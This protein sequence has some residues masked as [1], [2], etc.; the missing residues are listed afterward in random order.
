MKNGFRFKRNSGA[1]NFK[2]YKAKP[3]EVFP[4]NML[5]EIEGEVFFK[6][7]GG[8]NLIVKKHPSGRGEIYARVGESA[9]DK[10]K[11]EDAEKVLKVLEEL[12]AKNVRI[13]KFFITQDRHVIYLEKGK[14]YY[15]ALL[16]KG[17]EFPEK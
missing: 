8:R 9:E 15:I 7:K 10:E 17:L 11:G 3:G 13:N 5:T 4:D 14:Y 1:S 2:E 16:K 6:K 12:L